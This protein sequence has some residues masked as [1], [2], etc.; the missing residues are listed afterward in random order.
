MPLAPLHSACVLS[1]QHTR[2]MLPARA[3]RAL[4]FEKKE[5][6]GNTSFHNTHT[7][8]H[9]DPNGVLQPRSA[10]AVLRLHH[11]QA[12][13]TAAASRLGG[14]SLHVCLASAAWSPQVKT[15]TQRRTQQHAKHNAC[16]KKG[17]HEWQGVACRK[18]QADA[19]VSH[20]Q[21]R[22]WRSDQAAAAPW[23]AAAAPIK[24]HTH[25]DRSQ[26]GHRMT[27]SEPLDTLP[28]GHAGAASMQ[29][30]K[31]LRGCMLHKWRALPVRTMH[32][33][34]IQCGVANLDQG[35]HMHTPAARHGLEAAAA[36]DQQR[37]QQTI[38]ASTRH[39][40][41]PASCRCLRRCIHL[42]R[43]NTATVAGCRVRTAIAQHCHYHT[44]FHNPTT[45]NWQVHTTGFHHTPRGR[46]PAVGISCLHRTLQQ[47]K[48]AGTGLPL[49]LLLLMRVPQHS[50]VH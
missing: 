43:A 42:C 36:R 23:S 28:P 22:R 40:R 37:S 12:Q 19:A 11:T 48:A 15:H 3:P 34:A 6:K 24:Q 8:T 31:P 44:E 26:R 10:A 27:D 1:F 49:L 13:C 20:C 41:Q 14:C 21:T 46:I 18:S 29:L 47:R 50:L 25:T 33:I 9:H 7:H 16:T 38:D 17:T 45:V 32:G 39:G 35:R 2:K 5:K 30:S 4:L